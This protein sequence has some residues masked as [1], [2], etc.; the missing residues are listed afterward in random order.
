[1]EGGSGVVDQG[2]SASCPLAAGGAVYYPGQRQ[3][4]RRL[5]E[6]AFVGIPQGSLL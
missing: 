1:V 3:S 5:A 2:E 6:W 4:G